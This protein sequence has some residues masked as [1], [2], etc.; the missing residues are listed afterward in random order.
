MCRSDRKQCVSSVATTSSMWSWVALVNAGL[1]MQS[2]AVGI[3]DKDRPCVPFSRR[4]EPLQARPSTPALMQT[5]MNA[6]ERGVTAR[7]HK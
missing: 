2:T 6:K 7:K 3:V 4:A 1:F 5:A